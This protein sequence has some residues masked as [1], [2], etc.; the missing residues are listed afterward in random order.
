MT[1]WHREIV[2]LHRFFVDWYHARLPRTA[3]A[4]ARCGDALAEGFALI[5]PGGEILERDPLVA[6]LERAHGS[7]QGSD[8]E[9]RIE[10]PDAR[11]VGDGLLLARYEEWQRNAGIWRGRLSTTLLQEEPAAP[12]GLIW[13][14]VHETWLPDSATRPGG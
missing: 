8:F 1:P 12:A 3:A 5:S 9:I 13:L 4:F 6:M 7:R 11:A 2:D 10:R 14:H